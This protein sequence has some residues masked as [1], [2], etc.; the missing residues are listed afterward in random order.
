ME[1]LSLIAFALSIVALGLTIYYHNQSMF[2]LKVIAGESKSI[3]D[4]LFNN[5][6]VTDEEWQ[7][8][9][10]SNWKDANTP[11][12]TLKDKVTLI[13]ELQTLKRQAREYKKH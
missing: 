9:E 5:K 11:P 3:I 12:K 2:V 6:L 10:N 1:L 13:N 8:I 4:V 7:E